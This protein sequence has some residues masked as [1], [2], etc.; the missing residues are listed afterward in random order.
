MPADILVIR[1]VLDPDSFER[2]FWYVELVLDGPQGAYQYRR[3]DIPPNVTKAQAQAYIEANFDELYADAVARG[4][5]AGDLI[6]NPNLDLQ[7][8]LEAMARVMVDAINQLRS[9][10]GLPDMTYQQ[11]YDALRARYLELE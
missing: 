6:R 1:E 11:A 4:E 7:R 9:I 2:L 10:A 8:A 3:G 5:V